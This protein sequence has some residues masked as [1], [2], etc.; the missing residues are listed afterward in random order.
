MMNHAIFC[1]NTSSTA[2]ATATAT[3]SSS[4]C[5]HGRLPGPVSGDLE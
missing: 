3:T 5:R 1:H 4:L 2:T